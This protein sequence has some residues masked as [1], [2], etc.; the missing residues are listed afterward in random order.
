MKTLRALRTLAAL[1]SRPHPSNF[2]S[3]TF[4][5]RPYS[6]QPQEDSDHNDSDSVFNSADYVIPTGVSPSGAGDDRAPRQPTWSDEHRRRADKVL[7]HDK[8][9]R[10]LEVEEDVEEEKRRVLAKGLLQAALGAPD[11]EDDD[12]EKVV[13]EEDQKSLAVG[14]IGAPN[15]GK[16]ALTNH[17][18]SFCIFKDVHVLS[19]FWIYAIELFDRD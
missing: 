4:F 15:A 8:P 12:E 5:L 16:S 9:M 17:M 3:P 19:Y 13:S 11:D 6:A 7:F 14:I 1:H 10:V 18:V 2:T